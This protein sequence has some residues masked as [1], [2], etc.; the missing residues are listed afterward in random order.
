MSV[1]LTEAAALERLVA[2]IGSIGVACDNDVA[3]A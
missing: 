1:R 3:E 2:S